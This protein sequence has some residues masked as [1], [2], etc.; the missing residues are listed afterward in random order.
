MSRANESIAIREGDRDVRDQ[1]SDLWDVVNR[2]PGLVVCSLLVFLV[3]GLL[4]YLRVPRTFESTTDILIV[5][6]RAPA[7]EGPSEENPVFEK[8]IETHAVMV[9]SPLIVE[10]AIKDHNLT[11]LPTFEREEDPLESILDDLTV[12]VKEEN[13]TVLEVSYRSRNADDCQKVL[14]AIAATYKQFLGEFNQQIGKETTDL[15][16]KAN[17]DLMEQLRKNEEEY[18]RFQTSA[19]LMWRDGESV[20]V[21]HERQAQIETARQELMVERTVLR[22]RLDALNEV[23]AKGEVSR[24]AVYYEA[25]KEL[26][27]DEDYSD[28]RD[29]QIAERKRFA[30]REAVREY[31]SLLVGEYVRLMVEKSE[32]LDEF[33]EGHPNFESVVKRQEQVK[34]MLN[35]MLQNR[36]DVEESIL[37][38]ALLAQDKDENKDYVTIYLQLL[39]DRLTMLDRQ[40]TTLDAAFQAEQAL[41]NKMQEYLLRDQAFRNDHERTQQLFDVVVARLREI[42]LARDYAGDAMSILAEAEVGEQVWP[43]IP[44]VALGSIFLG[45]VGGCVLAWGVDRSERTFRSLAEIRQ[46]LGVP[47]LGRIP[48]MKRETIALLPQF[49]DVAARIV[50]VHMEG[51][52]LAEAFRG[53]RTSLYFTASGNIHQVIQITSPLPGDGKSTVAANLAVTIAKS[54]KRVLVLDADFRR[55]TIAR[56]LGLPSDDRQHG[57]AAVIAGKVSVME[58]ARLTPIDNLYVLPVTERPRQPSELLSTPEFERVLEKLRAEFDMVLIDTPPLLAVTDPSVVAARVD[59]VLLTMRI[60]KGVQLAATRAMEMLKSHGANVVGVII[61]GLERRRGYDAFRYGYEYPYMGYPAA[62]NGEENGHSPSVIPQTLTRT[63]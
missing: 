53:I 12:Q 27:L 9:C 16:A 54:G 18:R 30:E 40:I 3:L 62:S 28:W 63:S 43:R 7:L 23:L 17:D 39:S 47:V 8:S 44:Y 4:Y 58:A 49:P 52:N 42:S 48:F 31:A 1:L 5:T 20:N 59:A 6:K 46:A 61:N 14:A 21:H 10:R 26:Q 45:L 33:G 11:A 25:L 51:S 2:H 38:P 15:I 50:T 19:P 60:R 24:D 55:P 56:L 41:A 35:A 57:L 13:A 36:M 37:D 29:V 34:E 32:L 22:A